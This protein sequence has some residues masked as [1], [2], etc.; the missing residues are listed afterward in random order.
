MRIAARHVGGTK[1][2]TILQGSFVPLVVG[3]PTRMATNLR[4]RPPMDNALR[5]KQLPGDSA[6]RG[7]HGAASFAARRNPVGVG[8]GT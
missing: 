8:D 1:E 4:A 7:E 5:S 6:D 2:G 3:G